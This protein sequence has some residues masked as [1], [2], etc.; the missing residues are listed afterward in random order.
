[1]VASIAGV[2]NYMADVASHSFGQNHVSDSCFL[3]KF[4]NDFP[5]PQQLS[6]KHVHLTPEKILL[7]MTSTLCG[8]QLPL[9]Q[10]MTGFRL[11]NGTT[12]WN[13]APTLDKTRASRIAHLPSNNI[14]SSGLLHG[15]FKLALKTQKPR[16]VTWPKPFLSWQDTPIH[17]GPTVPPT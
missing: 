15:T 7:L 17:N 6:W 5:L 13:S 3:S 11:R 10:W 4:T 8:T 12:R 16:S 2:E 14:S 1:M 9:Q